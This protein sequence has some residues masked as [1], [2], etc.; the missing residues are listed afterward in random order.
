MSFSFVI[1]GQLLFYTDTFASMVHLQKDPYKELTYSKSF[2]RI[3]FQIIPL[4]SVKTYKALRNNQIQELLAKDQHRQ[5][6]IIWY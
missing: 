3:N 5:E 4:N 2:L 1:Y 6:L